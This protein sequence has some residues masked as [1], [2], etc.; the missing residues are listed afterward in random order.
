MNVLL[1]LPKAGSCSDICLLQKMLDVIETTSCNLCLYDIDSIH[2]GPI[3]I[4]VIIKKLPEE[5]CWELLRQ[6]PMGKWDL[7]RLLE[8][9]SKELASKEWCQFIKSS[10]TSQII[11]S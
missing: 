8:V 10:E 5:F 3:L 2:Y 4:S 9:V 7:A 11:G 6:M 1:S